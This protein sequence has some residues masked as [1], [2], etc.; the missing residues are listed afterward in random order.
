LILRFDRY[1]LDESRR[2][3][4]RDDGARVSLTTAEFEL[5]RVFVSHPQRSLTRAEV[6][7]LMAARAVRE[8][9]RSVDVTISRLRRKIEQDPHKPSL[10]KT[11]RDKGYFFA[12]AVHHEVAQ[13]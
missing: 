12:A 13:T 8:S 5:L 1:D 6:I 9:G 3:L 4:R 10:I 7:Q 11:V 2:E